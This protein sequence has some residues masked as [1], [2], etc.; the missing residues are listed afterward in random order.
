M[1]FKKIL[2]KINKNEKTSLATIIQKNKNSP[3]Q[4]GS[5]IIVTE[6]KK[7]Y[8][9][10]GQGKIE[11]ETYQ[12]MLTN[13][14]TQKIEIIKAKMDKKDMETTCSICGGDI[15]LLI[16]PIQ[17]EN[18][19]IYQQIVKNQENNKITILKTKIN[20]DNTLTKTIIEPDNSIMK[21][22]EKNK[23]YYANNEIIELIN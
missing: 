14:Q 12:H 20:Q 10:I 4:I 16:E 7:L 2:E 23:L 21:F 13:I 18:K 11:Q 8:G 5:K 19:T 15:F 22:L 3:R 17:K 9:N 1:I 6:N